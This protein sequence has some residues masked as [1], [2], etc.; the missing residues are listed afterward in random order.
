MIKFE[1]DTARL[2]AEVNK[3]AKAAE[4]AARPAAQEAA[5]IYYDLMRRYVP[6]SKAPHMFHG[7]NAVYGPYAPGSLRDAIYQAFSKDNSRDGVAEYHI[8]WNHQKVPY[9][10]MVE[11][12]TSRAAA[13]P[14]MRPAY[15]SGERAAMAAAEKRLL[16]ELRKAL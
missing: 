8:A 12:G 14:F 4:N 10:F 6:V 2:I 16:A 13:Q 1:D 11:Y 9:G 15:T 5:Q 7:E 3:L